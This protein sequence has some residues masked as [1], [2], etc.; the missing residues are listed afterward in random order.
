MV[1]PIIREEGDNTMWVWPCSTH[2]WCS[3][4]HRDLPTLRDVI[5]VIIQ[6]PGHSKVGYLFNFSNEELLNLNIL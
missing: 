1:A 2:L 4:L 6:I 3:P 5:S